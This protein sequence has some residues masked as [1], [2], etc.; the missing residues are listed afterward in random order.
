M[1]QIPPLQKLEHWTLVSSDIERTTQFYTE[2]LGAAQPERG[3]GPVSVNLA[4][5]VIDFIPAGGDRQPMPGSTGQHHAYIINLDDYDPWVEHLKANGVPVNL[6]THG[7]ERI[8]IYLDDPDGYHLELTVPIESE[9]IFR[10]EAEK[11]GLAI[12]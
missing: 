4:G 6:K 5:T 3:A 8:S 9:A 1:S 12:S 2:V 10:H 7:L 11:R